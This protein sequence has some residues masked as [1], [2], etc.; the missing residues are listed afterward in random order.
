MSMLPLGTSRRP[1]H[2]ARGDDVPAHPKAGR[3]TST[4]SYGDDVADDLADHA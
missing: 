4:L 2:D 1:E 3:R